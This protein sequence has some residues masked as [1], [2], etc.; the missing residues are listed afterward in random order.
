MHAIQFSGGKDSL[1]VLYQ[2]RPLLDQA[3]VYFGDTGGVYPHMVKFVHE[4]CK[5]LGRIYES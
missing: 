3:A 2:L 4:T 1:A 5:K